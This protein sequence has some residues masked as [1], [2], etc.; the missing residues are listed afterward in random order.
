MTILFR[1]LT[2]DGIWRAKI[3]L[4]KAS[5]AASWG[6]STT[7]TT[8]ATE[9]AATHVVIKWKVEWTLLLPRLG[10]GFQVKASW[11]LLVPQIPFFLLLNTYI[12]L[13]RWSIT[14]KL[15]HLS[16]VQLRHL[17]C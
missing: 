10:N 16:Q 17:N 1:R 12:K 4:L 8:S 15:A 6:P 5:S 13:E 14:L 9:T 7:S 3:S 11:V 2:K